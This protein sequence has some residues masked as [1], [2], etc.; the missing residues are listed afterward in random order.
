M[1]Q[2]THVFKTYFPETSGG[3]EEAIRQCGTYAA[4]KG[5]TVKVVCVGPADY[6]V[7]S[8][9]GIC[10]QFYKKTWDFFRDGRSLDWIPE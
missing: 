4:A 7:T 1:P 5:F 9:D 3:L 6:T 8:Q 10:T 2:V